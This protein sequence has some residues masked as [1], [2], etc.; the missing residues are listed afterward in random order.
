MIRTDLLNKQIFWV[1]GIQKVLS[2]GYAYLIES[3][4]AEFAMTQHCD[5]VTVGG[6]INLR[7]YA[8]ALPQGS[9]YREVGNIALLE[10]MEEGEVSALKDKW[11]KKNAKNC[12][13]V[14]ALLSSFAEFF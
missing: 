3:S 1:Q 10:L 4:S 9:P 14:S 8:L 13:Q 6:N 11:W 12:D 7:N 5:L 2:G